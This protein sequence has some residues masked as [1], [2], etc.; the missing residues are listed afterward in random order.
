MHSLCNKH[1]YLLLGIAVTA[2]VMPFGLTA[3]ALA[4]TVAGVSLVAWR[5]SAGAAFDADDMAFML[6]GGAVYLLWVKAILPT[7]G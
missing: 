5:Y 1:L 7:L 6:A 2:L 4:S 3:A